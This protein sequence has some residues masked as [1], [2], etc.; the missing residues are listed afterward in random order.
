MTRPSNIFLVGPMGSGKST[1]GRHL[2]EVLGRQFVDADREVEKRTGA[3]IA[4][5]FELEGEAGFRRRECAVI[6]DVTA[7]EDLVVATGGGA[8]LEPHNRALL[9]QRG[10]VVYLRA[11]LEVLVRRTR[12]DRNRPLLQTED[13]RARLERILQEREPLYREVADLIVETNHRTVRSVVNE[14]ARRLAQP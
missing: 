10:T 9:R 11:P 4:L 2:A 6:E 7:G 13:P 3:S 5:I 14:V 8:V 1:I 12:H